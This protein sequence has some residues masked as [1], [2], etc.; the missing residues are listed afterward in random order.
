M[1]LPRADLFSPLATRRRFCSFK[2]VAPRKNLDSL[3]IEG[4]FS[5]SGR[6]IKSAMCDLLRP[7]RTINRLSAH[8]APLTFAFSTPMSL[9]P[10]RVVLPE[11]RVH[12][13]ALTVRRDKN[14]FERWRSCVLLQPIQ[15]S[16]SSQCLTHLDLECAM[17]SPHY[18]QPFLNHTGSKLEVLI[19]HLSLSIIRA[20]NDPQTPAIAQLDLSPLVSLRSIKLCLSFEESR[21]DSIP[22]PILDS[23]FCFSYVISLLAPFRTSHTMG[24]VTLE[25]TIAEHPD[26]QRHTFDDGLDWSGM[27]TALTS[28]PEL[29]KVLVALIDR[30]GSRFAGRFFSR[31]NS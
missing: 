18:I 9:D 4:P 7:F 6:F 11:L 15:L 3:Y 20:G 5:T 22:N 28:I 29:E 26:S 30:D 1:T 25:L 16:S 23:Q 10:A 2:L 24:E 19:L 21:D 27:D 8:Q 12:S 14:P 17:Y 13:L 31:R